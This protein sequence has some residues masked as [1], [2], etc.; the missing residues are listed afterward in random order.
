MTRLLWLLGAALYAA[1]TPLLTQP[2]LDGGS[3]SLAAAHE[4]VVA[5][6]VPSL[7]FDPGSPKLPVPAPAQAAAKPEA[8][9]PSARSSP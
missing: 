6:Q 9:E 8:I 4:T 7:A 2:F 3:A 1:A 5:K